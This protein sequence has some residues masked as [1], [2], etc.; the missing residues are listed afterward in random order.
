[1]SGFPCSSVLP[2]EGTWC[3]LEGESEH[4]VEGGKGAAEGG[5][6]CVCVV[7]VG[8]IHIRERGS[9]L[10]STVQFTSV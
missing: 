4:F 9:S 10:C 6:G 7:E 8:K 2:G 5:E 1:M 3:T